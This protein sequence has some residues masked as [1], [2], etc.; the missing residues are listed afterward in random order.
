MLQERE[1]S[2]AGAAARRIVDSHIT[3]VFPALRISIEAPHSI[4]DTAP[5]ATPIRRGFMRKVHPV[6]SSVETARST[7]TRLSHDSTRPTKLTVAVPK[8]PPGLTPAAARALLRLIQN[9][10]SEAAIPQTPEH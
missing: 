4:W 9:A 2:E 8:D 3:E 7:P 5:L 6:D 1:S 10:A